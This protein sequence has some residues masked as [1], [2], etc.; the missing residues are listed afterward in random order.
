MNPL[1]SPRATRLVKQER[2]MHAD[3]INPCLNISELDGNGPFL[4]GVVVNALKK[5]G[6]NQEIIDAYIE[7]ATA[8][9]DELLVASYHYAGMGTSVKVSGEV[10]FSYVGTLEDKEVEADL[11]DSVATH[12]HH[13]YLKS[14]GKPPR[15]ITARERIDRAILAIQLE[16]LSVDR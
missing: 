10:V 3:W 6:N 9:Y 14:Q 12:S 4:L 16:A 1:F 2:D 5:A 11:S 15:E 7:E 13:E 8:G